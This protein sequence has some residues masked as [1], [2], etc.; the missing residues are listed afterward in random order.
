[1]QVYSV[2]NKNKSVE[3]SEQKK[4]NIILKDKIDNFDLD[5]QMDTG[6]EVMLIPRNFWERIGKLTLQKSKLL[7]HQFDG[8]VIKT[9]RY[10]EGSLF[11]HSCFCFI[12]VVFLY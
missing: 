9:L 10:F 7:L 3:K 4:K 12:M 2:K 6:S 1:M 8:S 11:L 5:I